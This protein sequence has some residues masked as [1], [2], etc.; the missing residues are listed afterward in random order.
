MVPITPASVTSTVGCGGS[1]QYSSSSHKCVTP[2]G[3]QIKHL[4]WLAPRPDV[5]V[6]DG[7]VVGR[8]PT[9]VGVLRG[10]P[11]VPERSTEASTL[12]VDASQC[13]GPGFVFLAPSLESHVERTLL[14]GFSPQYD[15]PT[16]PNTLIGKAFD[17]IYQ[18][19]ERHTDVRLRPGENGVR[20]ASG[21]PVDLLMRY[22]PWSPIRDP[23]NGF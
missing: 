23:L 10:V 4:V 3:Y 21:E 8:A 19:F 11:E 1:H 13:D 5:V 6:V 20:G 18:R 7:K 9:I 2:F 15:A 17:A 14:V 22:D 16:A 12:T